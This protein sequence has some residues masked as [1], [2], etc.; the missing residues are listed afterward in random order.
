M[1][2]PEAPTIVT[3]LPLV[4]LESSV[5][6]DRGRAVG[7]PDASDDDPAHAGAPAQG[8]SRR[9][10]AREQPVELKASSVIQAT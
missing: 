10:S 6:E 7:F 4:D 2:Q 1:P 5:L 9:D 3:K 8:K